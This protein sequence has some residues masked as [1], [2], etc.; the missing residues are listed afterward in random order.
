M[1]SCEIL[2]HLVDQHNILPAAAQAQPA[3]DDTFAGMHLDADLALAVDTAVG[4]A[5]LPRLPATVSFCGVKQ[6]DAALSGVI[7]NRE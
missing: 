6:R 2:G 1:R 7:H 3:A 4:S 5:I